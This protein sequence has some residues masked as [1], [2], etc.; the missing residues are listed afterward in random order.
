MR[1]NSQLINAILIILQKLLKYFNGA[2]ILTAFL[3]LFLVKSVIFCLYL[4]EALLPAK[5]SRAPA[6]VKA[7]STLK[8]CYKLPDIFE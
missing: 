6:S 5:F 4:N 2:I 1:L 3:P 7:G 8:Y